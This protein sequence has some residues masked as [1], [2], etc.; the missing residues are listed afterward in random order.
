MLHSEFS[1]TQFA[2]FFQ[3]RRTE[4]DTYL[5]IIS[6]LAFN[7]SGYLFHEYHKSFSAKAALYIQRFNIELDWSV[8]DLELLSRHFTGHKTKSCSICGSFSHTANL[9]PRTAYETSH[10]KADQSFK[11]D[12]ESKVSRV[13]GLPSKGRVLEVSSMPVCINFNESVC[14]YLKCKFLHCCAI[15]GDCQGVSVTSP[16]STLTCSRSPR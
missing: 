1:E 9:C 16:V 8:V 2:R 7:Y 5:A 4:L 6:D 15:C 11:S 12:I 13:Q 10:G 14:L 3:I